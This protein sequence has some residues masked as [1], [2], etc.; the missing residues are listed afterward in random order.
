MTKL[1]EQ[2]G[3]TKY[4]DDGHLIRYAVSEPYMI[5]DGKFFSHP[6]STVAE[7]L[8]PVSL[9]MVTD[10]LNDI[11]WLVEEGSGSISKDLTWRLRYAR[12]LASLRLMAN[13]R[14]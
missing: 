10:G 8:R 9:A 6:Y 14:V 2:G 5:L 11:R 7:N 3:F 12:A 1:V 4:L 13:W